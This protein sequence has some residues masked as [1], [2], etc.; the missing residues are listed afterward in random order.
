LTAV[1]VPIKLLHEG[2]GHGVTVELKNGEVY[3]GHLDEAEDTMNCFM[4]GVTMT[5]RDGR[6]SKL[7]QVYLRG[8]HVK[9]IVLPDVLKNA[10]VF[11][12]VQKMKK[13]DEASGKGTG[14]FKKGKKAGKST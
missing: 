1:G 4:T 14:S 6:V 13:K 8:S 10:P 9:L 5:G 2:E 11:K 3:R 7:E 12:P